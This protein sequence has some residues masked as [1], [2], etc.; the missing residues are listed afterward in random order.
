MLYARPI[1]ALAWLYGP[2][3]PIPEFMPIS[4]RI[5]PLTIAMVAKDVVELERPVM[6]LASAPG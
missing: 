5:G 1:V 3:A 4:L 6:P 2:K